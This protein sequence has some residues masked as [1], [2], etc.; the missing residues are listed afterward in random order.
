M[1]VRSR[2]VTNFWD[3]VYATDFTLDQLRRRCTHLGRVL[4]DRGWSCLVAYDTRFMSNLFARDVYA[5]LADQQVSVRLAPTSAPLPAVYYALNRQLAD[6]ALVVSARNHPYWYNGLVLIS[7]EHPDLHLQLAEAAG[8]RPFPPPAESQPELFADLRDPYLAA[9]GEHV[10]LEL[11]RRAT[12][13][14]FVDPVHGTTS[15]YLPTLIGG[16]GQTRA[17]EINR[18]SD[19]LFSKLTPL[20]TASGLNRLKKLVRESDSHLGVALSADGTAL[21]MVDKNGAQLDLLEIVLLLAAYL[22]RQYRHKGLVIVPQPAPDAPIAPPPAGVASWEEAVGLKLELAADPRARIAEMLAQN[23]NQ[24][25]IGC[26]NEGELV[27]G[28]YGAYPDAMLAALLFVELVAR[29]AGNL[30][31][32]IDELHTRLRIADPQA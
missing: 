1:S 6:C 17:I 5:G 27:L 9:L 31:A 29:N 4:K 19:P 21:G 14:I 7:P 23:R 28:R 11:I 16:E 3:G 18:E 8:E 24:L 13:T 2:L 22:V 30:R 25:L 26:T 20:P 10:D 15:N 32:L 12:L